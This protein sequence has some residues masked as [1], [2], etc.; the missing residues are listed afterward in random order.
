M[1]V[2]ILQKQTWVVK[3]KTFEST[4]PKYLLSGPFRKMS[5]DTQSRITLGGQ[6][7]N[8][9]SDLKY[10]RMGTGRESGTHDPTP[11]KQGPISHGSRGGKFRLWLSSRPVATSSE[12]PGAFV[13]GR[14]RNP[15]QWSS[16]RGR[17]RVKTGKGKVNMS[18][19]PG[20]ALDWGCHHC[21]Q[22]TIS[23]CWKAEMTRT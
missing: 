18:E 1:A 9:L 5:M 23:I 20:H 11:L 21:C 12:L 7:D 6:R 2:S 4:K 13:P 17:E 16:A 14:W 15:T 22:R 8:M 19:G 3:T 10:W